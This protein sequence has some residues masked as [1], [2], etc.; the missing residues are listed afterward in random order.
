MI[1]SEAEYLINRILSGFTKC[2]IRDV[3]FNYLNL[4]IKNPSRYH[5]Y[6]ASEIYNDIYEECLMSGLYTEEELQEFLF[7]NELWDSEREEKLVSLQKDIDELK[8]R[9]Y[10]SSFNSQALL[11]AK[12]VIRAAKADVQKLFEEKNGYNHLAA[13]GFAEIEKNKFLI[14]MSL[15]HIN[16]ELF[17]DEE[18]YWSSPVFILE[19]ALTIHRQHKLNETQFRW[20]ARNEPWRSYWISRKAEGSLIGVSPVDMSDDQRSLIIWSSIY[21]NVYEHPEQPPS[22]VVE[23]DDVLDGWFI[24]QRKKREKET[25]QS[26]A[27]QMITNDKIKNSGEIFIPASAKEDLQRIASLNDTYGDI[28]KKQRLLHVSKNGMVPESQMPDT[29]IDLRKQRAEMF[30]NAV[31]G[32]V[33][34]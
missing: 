22:Y 33:G 23:D 30:K 8:L 19:Q 2:K 9:M 4:V 11:T 14:G 5:K 18:S 20:L 21:D 1:Y 16:G 13:T 34:G 29:K 24:A 26:A 28:T 3:S 27:D 31:K 10:E 25:N 15:F 7:D 32:N 17:M 12:R 6:L